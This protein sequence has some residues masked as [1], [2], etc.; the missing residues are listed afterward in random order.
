MSTL[1]ESVCSGATAQ[2]VLS[3]GMIAMGQSI[4]VSFIRP[5]TGGLGRGERPSSPSWAHHL[6]LGRRGPQRA[7]GKLC[8]L[9]QMTIAVRLLSRERLTPEAVRD[10]QTADRD[11]RPL[12]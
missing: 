2:A 5:I 4:N 11:R 6:G 12:A 8:A 7:D 1:V 9:A 3:D 10:R